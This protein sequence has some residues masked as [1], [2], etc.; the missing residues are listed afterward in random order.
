M[1]E[2]DTENPADFY[3]ACP[4]C[5]SFVDI[6]ARSDG[7]ETIESHNERS[8]DGDDTAYAVNIRDMDELASFLQDMKTQ[9]DGD[10][11]QNFIRQMHHG[12]AP[13]FCSAKMFKQAVP[14]EDRVHAV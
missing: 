12:N 14:K 6:N 5:V 13:F 7:D 1:S 2:S 3:V 10:Q 9:S 8:H 11:Y 4:A